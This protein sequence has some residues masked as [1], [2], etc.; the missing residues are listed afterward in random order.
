[1]QMLNQFILIIKQV[2]IITDIQTY[3]KIYQYHFKGKING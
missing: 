1:M 3:K 2:E